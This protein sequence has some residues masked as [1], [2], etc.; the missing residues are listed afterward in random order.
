MPHVAPFGAFRLLT[1][2]QG[3]QI[4]IQHQ[5]VLQQVLVL[6][7]PIPTKD[8]G[9]CLLHSDHIGLRSSIQGVSQHRLLGT[10][11]QAEGRG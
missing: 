11:R 9:H 8:V 4:D 3:R 6:R 1:R 2:W 5:E 7:L 10:A